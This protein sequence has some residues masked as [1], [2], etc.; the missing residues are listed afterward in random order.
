VYI[1]AG[2]IVFIDVTPGVAGI[3]KSNFY[4]IK[5]F[6]SSDLPQPPRGPAGC[7]FFGTPSSANAIKLSHSAR[8]TLIN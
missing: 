8:E 2:A 7:S 4:I 3:E 1:I 6:L 5:Y